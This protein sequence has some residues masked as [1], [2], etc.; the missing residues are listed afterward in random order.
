MFLDVPMHVFTLFRVFAYVDQ[1]YWACPIMF[2][3]YRTL[4]Y[5]MILNIE[6]V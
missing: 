3:G 5:L 2:M 1:V 6:G 4:A